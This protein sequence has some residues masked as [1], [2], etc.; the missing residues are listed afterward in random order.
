MQK[1]RKQGH[2]PPLDVDALWAL[3]RI[4][5]PSLSPDGASACATVTS[6]D[7]ARNDGRTALWLFPT[8]IGAARG[9]PRMLTAGDKDS[10]PCWSPDG[11]QIAFT[12]K[13]HD[14]TQ[15]QVYLIA[16]DGGE[17][18][19]V[20]SQATGCA[21]LKWFADSKRIAFV[22]W[23]WRDLASDALQAKRLL[24]HSS[25][26]V[27]AHVTERAEYRFW[28][29]WLA[30]GREPHVF[31]CDVASGRCRDLFAGTGIALPPWDPSASDFDLAPDG[32]E[33]AASV[34]LAAEPGMMNRRD[35]VLVNTRTRRKRTLT[36]GSGMDNAHPVYAP[37]GRRLVQIAFDTA[38]AF[39]DQG[40]LR[41]VDRGSGAVTRVAARL[42]RQV[43]QVRFA[44]DGR[45]LLFTCEDRGRVNLCRLD[46][47]EGSLALLAQGGTIGGYSQ[48]RDGAVIA[49]DRATYA[50]PPAL[51][52]TSADGSQERAI[53]S[54]NG[55]LLARHAFGETREFTVRGWNG[56]PVQMWV[57]FP[58]DFDPRRKWP[59]MHSIHG[60]P[61]AAH[62]DAW[63]FRW[64]S[65]VF[66][67]QG[68]V[69]AMVNY[70]G[71]SGFGQK[72]I[73][74]ITGRY[75]SKEFADVE[76]GTDY[77]LARGYIDRARLAATGGSYGGYMV[78][79]MNGHTDR[80][81]SYVCHAGCYDWVSMMATDGYRFFA[82]EL[83]AYYWNNMPR[84]MSQ[85]PHHFVRRACT[86]T[87]VMHGE[88]DYRVPA[89][90]GLQY[91]NTLKAKDVDARL[92]YFPDE[93]HWIL[94]PQ[95][96]RLWYREFFAWLRRYAPGG[97]A[98]KSR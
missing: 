11:R 30:D 58:P 61:H 93:N 42:D 15:P 49:F 76:A 35:I 75:G 22:S 45:G 27:K 84:V 90:Q 98:R 1:G 39:N 77:L 68:Y 78:A 32:G 12:A 2:K 79:Y 53:E 67:G 21:S 59:L 66:A 89:A 60:G 46:L 86:P 5:S 57:T 50:N 36:A 34:D 63:H 73:E 18:R 48:S 91:Y 88:L 96:S 74:S 95:N 17:A 33:I 55:A 72:F 29:H 56:E 47:A 71:S 26:K 20:T 85:S 38:R 13:R 37:D 10:D 92:V 83:G 44:P 24:S 64:N 52:V 69:V 19:R 6:F 81:K 3:K 65:H 8:G 43:T 16:V 70:H 51:Y 28:D 94:K 40:H 23:V 62:H 4:G 80:Y 9:K 25:D 31:A 87:L 7:M 82:S 54:L 97:A 14:D 41:I